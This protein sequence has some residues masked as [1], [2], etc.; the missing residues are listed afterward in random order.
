M[1]SNYLLPKDEDFKD[2]YRKIHFFPEVKFDVTIFNE[3]FLWAGL[4]V[5]KVTGETEPRLQEETKWT[6]NF[7]SFGCSYKT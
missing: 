1:M 3:F 2:F 6:Q 4:G 5:S 7:L